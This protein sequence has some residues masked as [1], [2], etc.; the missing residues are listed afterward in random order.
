MFFRSKEGQVQILKE[1]SSNRGALSVIQQWEI[2]TQSINVKT[3]GSTG[4]PKI[5]TLSK[6]QIVASIQSSSDY[7]GWTSDDLFVCN[8]SIESIAGQMMLLRAVELN[9]AILYLPPS[10]SPVETLLSQAETLITYRQKLILALVPL[11]LEQSVKSQKGIN[12]LNMAKTILIGG[13]AVSTSLKSKINSL[14]APIF[15]TYGMTETVTHIAV[16]DLSSS[17]GNNHFKTLPQ[18]TIKTDDRACLQIKAPQTLSKWIST[19]DIVQIIDEQSFRYIGRADNTINSGGVKLQLETIE[20]SIATALKQPFSFFAF[21]ME[22]EVLGQALS[23]AFIPTAG[24]TNVFNKTY[25]KE[26]LPKFEVPRYYFPVE[27]FELTTS[28]KIDKTKTVDVHIRDQF[29]D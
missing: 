10:S 9:A 23:I 4:S 21:A 24:S 26:V 13:A 7:F 22:D 1:H 28:G 2:G 29:S 15:A 18:V 11:Q 17:S 8:L 25:M 19:N 3:S 6:E 5:I 20:S 16:Q 27:R 14:S 12:T